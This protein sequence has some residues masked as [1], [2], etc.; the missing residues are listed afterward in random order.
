[1]AW[2]DR[3]KELMHDKGINQKELSGLSGI[4]E[5][6]ISRYLK[7]E[8]RARMD[9]VM[10]IAKA[11]NVKVEYLLEDDDTLSLSPFADISTAIARN[12]K[13]LSA[14]EKNK[15]ISMILEQGD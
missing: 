6:S 13:E 11:L 15:L 12:G 1:M 2:Q 8:R 9:V 10:N 5:A 3:V 4:T 7:E 14:E